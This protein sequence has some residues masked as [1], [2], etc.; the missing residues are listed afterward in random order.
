MAKC[1][2]YHSAEEHQ[3]ADEKSSA[4]FRGTRKSRLSPRLISFCFLILWTC[5][6][7][8]PLG[9]SKISVLCQETVGDT[10][11]F[12]PFVP[13][14]GKNLIT[15]ASAVSPILGGLNLGPHTV[16]RSVPL[17]L[18]EPQICCPAGHS[19]VVPNQS[20]SAPSVFAMLGRACGLG[21]FFCLSGV[22]LVP[23]PPF[24]FSFCGPGRMR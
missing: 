4:L 11:H 19:A 17:P 15:S 3:S 13:S 14:P 12:C 9:R 18:G 6:E 2:C 7:R 24:K 20:P 22:G 1:Y 21:L 5:G 16:S 10:G 8:L 23:M